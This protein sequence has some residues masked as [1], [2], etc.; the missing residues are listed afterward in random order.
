MGFTIDSGSLIEGIGIKNEPIPA[1]VTEICQN[2]F[3]KSKSTLQILTFSGSLLECIR[4]YAFAECVYLT[5][6]D[7]SKCDRCT[8]IERFA[9][10]YCYKLTKL[11]LSPGI[12]TMGSNVFRESAINETINLTCLECSTDTFLGNPTSFTTENASLFYRMYENNIYNLDYTKICYV[13]YSTDV[14][15]LHANTKIIGSSSFSTTS[16]KEVIIPP[17]ITQMNIFAFH[18]TLNLEHLTLSPNIKSIVAYSIFV[19]PKLLSLTIPEGVETIEASSV[20]DVNKLRYIKIPE[21]LTNIAKKSF[22]VP[23]KLRYVT[24][25]PNQ[26]HSLVEGG[27]PKRALIAVTCHCKHSMF[28]QRITLML[29]LLSS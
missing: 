26:F 15:R 3:S 6:V 24:Y 12:K 20:T 2:A 25:K 22:I 17:Q 10:A 21:T 9:F 29:M 7:L 23:D 5:E 18:H 8:T 11:K 1:E 27:I 16:L 19:N 28:N 14:L 4:Q 13:S